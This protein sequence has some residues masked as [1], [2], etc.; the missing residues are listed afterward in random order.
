M[1]SSFYIEKQVGILLHIL[2]LVSS[3]CHFLHDDK[4]SMRCSGLYN[5]SISIK[6]IT[7]FLSLFSIKINNLDPIP[8][9]VCKQR[10][11]QMSNEND[12]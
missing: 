11:L 9:I 6:Q 10:Y 4:I 1:F 2:N 12:I 7:F 5:Y 3:Y 8:V